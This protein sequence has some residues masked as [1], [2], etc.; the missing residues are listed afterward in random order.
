[1]AGFDPSTEGLAHGTLAHDNRVDGEL[2]YALPA[3]SRMNR[4]GLCGSDIAAIHRRKTAESGQ[5]VVAQ[6]GDEVTL[7]RF[8]ADR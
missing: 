7:K 8:R 2:G 1:M 4:T 3:G 6:F 5:V